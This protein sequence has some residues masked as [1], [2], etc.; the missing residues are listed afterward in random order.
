MQ[1]FRLLFAFV[2]VLLT[3]LVVFT[4]ASVLIVVTTLADRQVGAGCSIDGVAASFR[5]RIGIRRCR[6][7]GLTEE[8]LDDR[9]LGSVE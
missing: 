3:A 7:G 4:P 9:I 5:R 2:F 1:G 8:I 6:S